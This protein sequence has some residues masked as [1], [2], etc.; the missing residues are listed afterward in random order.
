MPNRFFIVCDIL[1]IILINVILWASLYIQFTQ[2]QLPCPLC[3]AQRMGILGIGLG[4]VL[5]LYFG[6]RARHYALGVIIALLSATIAMLHI[7]LHIV[8]ET[9][10]YGIP[11]FGMHL[12]TWTFIVCILFALG[13]LVLITLLSNPAFTSKTEPV[14]SN[15][16]CITIIATVPLILCILA[17]A[18]SAYAECGLN[19]CPP[20]PKSYWIN[21]FLKT[22]KIQKHHSKKNML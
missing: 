20:D 11:L 8:P 5:N 2:F 3:L 6:T 12:Y 9:G 21:D 16:L 1:A 4:Y 22:D 14:A 19:R 7:L 17:N 18:A 15:C 10:S 13:N